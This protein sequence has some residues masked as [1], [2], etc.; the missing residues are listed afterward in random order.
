MLRPGP[1]TFLRS[2]GVAM[3]RQPTAATRAPPTR[4]RLVARRA[5]PPDLLDDL[6]YLDDS[7]PDL[8]RALGAA[9]STPVAHVLARGVTLFT[10]M[11]CGLNWWFY[12]GLGVDPEKRDGDKP[13]EDKDK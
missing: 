4:A 5:I 9:A 8:L 6:P 2:S 13:E 11:Y 3:C 10:M 12:R 1:L 7:A